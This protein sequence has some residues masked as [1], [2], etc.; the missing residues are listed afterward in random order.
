VTGG[1]PA[2]AADLRVR[3]APG[4]LLVDFGGPRRVLSSAVLGGGIGVARGWLNATVPTD[5]D[6]LD[7]A[8]DLAERAAAIGFEGPLVGMLTAVD[9]ARCERARH[10]AATVFATVGVGH[11]L[12]AAGTRPRAVPAAGTIN[13]LVLLDAALDD[14]ALAGA[15]QTAIEAKAQALAAAGVPARNADCHATGTA[16]DSFCVAALPGGGLPF[17]GPATKIGADLAQ[18]VHAAVLAGALA[19]RADFGPL[20]DTGR[21][22]LP[23]G[24][25]GAGAAQAAVLAAPRT[26]PA[27]A[28]AP[29][30]ASLPAA[31]SRT[32]PS[33]AATAPAATPPAAAPLT[34]SAAAAPPPAAPPPT[35]DAH[36]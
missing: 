25:A 1:A 5:Y 31:A 15:A 10:G 11:A 14:A 24:S 34:S 23:A 8:A 2:G 4:T 26:S 35:P 36:R 30:A 32:S 12:A 21:L 29:P 28:A 3:T 18:A 27:V 17:A 6:R 20:Y 13:L 7:P 16:T 22:P 19:D 9:V 33:G